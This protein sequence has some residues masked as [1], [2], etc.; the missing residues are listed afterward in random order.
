MKKQFFLIM[1]LLALVGEVHAQKFL[2]IYHDG[3]IVSSVRASDVDS[4]VA[5]MDN[6]KRSLDFYKDGEIFHHTVAANVDS[7]KVFR[8]DD[9][10]LVW[11]GIVGFNQELYDKAFGVLNKSTAGDFKTF[12]NNLTRKDGTLLYYGVDHALDM[13]AN[14]PFPTQV[15][16]VNL[17]TFTDGLDQG[18]MM[19]STRYTTDEQYLAAVSSR[20]KGMKIKNLPLTAYSLGL[21]GNDVSNYSLFQDNLRQLASSEEKAF[22]VSSMSAVRTRLQDISDQIISISNKQ[23]VSM[24]I[25]GQSDGTLIRFTF[26]GSA[27]SS[28]MYI[29]GTFN[30]SDR[31]LRNVSYHGITSESGAMVQ[32]KQSGIFVTYTFAGLRR[33]DGSGLI[34]MSYIRQ[35]YKSAAATSWQENSEF[36]PENNT[37]TTITHSGTVIM[38]VLD[39]SSSLG[40][41]FSD[42]K[43]YAN[44]FIDRVAANA[45]ETLARPFGNHCYNGEH[46]YLT[47]PDDHHPHMIDLGLPSGTKWAC[48]NVDTDHPENQSPTNYGG[49]YAWGETETKTTYIWSTYKYY[50]NGSFVSLG[51]DIAGTQYD[52]AHVKWGGS[53]VMPSLDQIKELFDNCSSEWTTFNGANGRQF[54]GKNGGTIFLPAAGDRWGG[55]LNNA[56]SGG[57]YGSSTQDS[58]YSDVAYGLYFS[59]GA[60]YW[61]YGSSR[62]SGHTVRPVTSN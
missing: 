61:N 9:E 20:I 8:T 29:E 56:G 37:Q 19:M 3:K 28:S 60:A 36:T 1:A 50:Q 54:T 48:C 17:I 2:D 52:V 18:S 27:N 39:C 32:G 62:Y 45:A 7:V 5:K 33:A 35:Y 51:S 15:S 4:L 44:D 59:S 58:S 24:K 41:Q 57:Y 22:E 40:S 13:L 21:R 25:P 47:C 14:T 30:L 23:T 31:S 11:L 46:S 10:P 16:S 43:N 55:G 38:L 53:W 34:P 26:D 49:Y 12:V 6:D 42:M